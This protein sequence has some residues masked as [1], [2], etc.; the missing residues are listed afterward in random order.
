MLKFSKLA[1]AAAFAALAAAAMAAA[2]SEVEVLHY[3]T[4]GGE[5]KSVAELK[6][7]M[8]SRGYSWKDFAVTG[9]GGENAMSVLKKR[10]LAGNPPAAALIKGPTIQEWANLN[11]LTN[12]DTMA[13][14]DRWDEALP[15]VIADQMKYQGHYVAVPVNV[16]RV[17]WLWGNSAVLKKAGVTA[18]PK[19]YEEF[20]VAADKIRAAGFIALAHGG[21]DWQDFTVF[22]SVALGVGGTAFYNKALV[23][24]DEAALTGNEM[25][26]TL[27]VLRRLKPYTDDKS[28]GRDWNQATALVI[29]G[30]AGFQ[31]MG[32]WAKGEFLAANQ[33]PGK[34]FS[35]TPAPGTAHA[36]SFNVDSFAMFQLKS[37]EARKAQGY[38]AFL[39]MGQNFQEQFNLRKGSIPARLNMNLEKFDE[40]AKLSG[41][42]FS[43]M[44]K[45]G[46][47]VPSVAHGM[48]VAPAVQSALRAA[49]SDFWNNDKATV[50]ET[51]ARLAL[52]AR[53]T[54]K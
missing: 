53:A 5:A 51:L 42:D 54:A 35:C 33:E 14:F 27:E 9:G 32:D 48:A 8:A 24:L 49:V 10:V 1:A 28:A 36:Y 40:C 39:L 11:V 3:W 21:Q 26:K 19:T 29:A 31:L 34:D 18:L 45:T 12:L 15:K 43:A 25:R 2:A 16:H 4:S 30:K 23:K 41:Q 13:Q 52:A 44:A 22:E 50:N 47:L 17:N 6:T 37:G 46:A 20:F 38:L 7:L